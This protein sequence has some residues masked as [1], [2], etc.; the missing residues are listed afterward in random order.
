MNDKL[1]VIQKHFTE[2]ADQY[3]RLTLATGDHDEL[4]VR[5]ELEFSATYETVNIR[6][7]FQIEILFPDNYPDNP[8]FVK[9]TGGRIPTDFHTYPNGTLCLGAPIE[10]RMKYMATRS[11]LGFVK[12]LVIPFLFSFCYFQKFGK[13]P[14]GELSH[15]DKGLLEYY[16]ELFNTSSH[17]ATIGLLKVLAENNYKGHHA[18]P[19]GSSSRIRDCHGELFRKLTLYRSSDE[20]LYDYLQCLTHLDKIG[21]KIPGSLYSKKLAKLIEKNSRNFNK[22]GRD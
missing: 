19:C 9:E 7:N 11:L 20:F 10:I 17:V 18:C 2:L 15:G 8:P 4:L 21:Q 5:G 22:K 1:A 12:E 13:M 6:D 3:P 14:Y 16:A